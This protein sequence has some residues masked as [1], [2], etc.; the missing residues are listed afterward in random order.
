[1][2]ELP[3]SSPALRAFARAAF[4]R[5][6]PGYQL[7]IDVDSAGASEV[8]YAVFAADL[9]QR[10]RRSP[11]SIRRRVSLEPLRTDVAGS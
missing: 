8:A 11:R 5:G 10:L 7:R 6:L 2:L 4:R 9:E 1:M 3:A